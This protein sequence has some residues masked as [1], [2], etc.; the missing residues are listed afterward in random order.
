MENYQIFLFTLLIAKQVKNPATQNSRLR[1]VLLCQ[2]KLEGKYNC[3]CSLP[4]GQ[5]VEMRLII[6]VVFVMSWYFQVCEYRSSFYSDVF[7]HFR[8]WHEDTRHLLCQYCLKVFKHSTSYQ[9][10][11]NRHQVS[12]NEKL[13]A[14]TYSTCSLLYSWQCYS[15]L[16]RSKWMHCFNISKKKKSCCYQLTQHTLTNIL[17]HYMTFFIF[18]RSQQFTTV[19]NAVFSSCSQKIKLSIKSITTGLSESLVNWRDSSLGQK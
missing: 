10:H 5:T 11:Y 15:L 1:M 16:K 17:S 2:T 4:F 6:V 9:Q 14:N 7:N 3:D 13:H 19:T 12:I 18:Y 8:T